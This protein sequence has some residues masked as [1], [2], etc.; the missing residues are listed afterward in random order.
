[1]NR[2]LI[3]SQAVVVC[4]LALSITQAHAQQGS[5]ISLGRLSTGATVN[6]VKAASGEWGID[7][8]GNGTPHISQ[9]QPARFEVYTG[10]L[11]GPGSK[12]DLHE[13]AAGYQT[14]Q[15]AG[16]TATAKADISFGA[17]VTFHVEDRWSLKDLV[18]SVHRRVEVAGSAQGGFDSAVLFS[19]APDVNWTDLE[20]MVPGRLY[21]DPTYDGA[22]SSGGPLH[23]AAKRLSMRE[24]SL[25]APLFAMN[26]REGHSVTVFDPTP[27]GDTTVEEASAPTNN[28]MIDGKYTFGA[29]GAHENPNG[30][31]FG[32]WLPGTTN[33]FLGGGR[34]GGGRAGAPSPGA[35]PAALTPDG[36][37]APPPVITPVPAWRRRY[38]PI[39]QGMVQDYN[40]AFR[41]G[42]NETFPATTRNAFRWAWDTLKP[43]VNY[44]DL[45]YVRRTVIDVHSSQVLTIEGRTGVPYLLD[46]RTGKFRDR[47][48]A[49]RAAMGFCGRNIEVADEFLK[50]ADRE[51]NTPRSQKLRKQA[52]DLIATFIQIGRAHV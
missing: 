52:L 17:G 46:A 35:A 12:D 10:S 37:L 28:V 26:F 51:P 5:T 8:A 33:D 41:F 2:K 14:V 27:K 45:D 16:G 47:S 36:N 20:F 48:D 22:T 1:M 19:T 21:A 38:N 42:Q 15:M 34:G 39:Q 30:V 40:V 50:E 29:V 9:P 23:Y 24:N 31:E 32:Y 13:V 3:R 6:F 44:V 43:V 7:V 4:T 25:P 49:K 18:L 11:P